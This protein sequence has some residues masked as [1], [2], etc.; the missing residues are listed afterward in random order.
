MERAERRFQRSRRRGGRDPRAERPYR[1]SGAIG[2]SGGDTRRHE[3]DVRIGHCKQQSPV[4]GQ[5]SQVRRQNVWF[6][7][8]DGH[9]YSVL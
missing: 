8:D 2:T 7:A 9:L 6:S 1:H 3:R 5:P 4:H